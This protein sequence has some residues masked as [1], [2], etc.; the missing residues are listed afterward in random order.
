[1]EITNRVRML[2]LAA[3]LGTAVYFS[4]VVAPSAFGVL[5]SFELSNASEVAGAIVSRTLS[6]VNKTGALLSFLLL[7]TTLSVRR[8]YGRTS[9]ILQNVLLAVVVIATAIGEWVIAPRMVSLRVLMRGQI[10]QIPLT[11]P[12]RITFMALH[13]YSVAALGVAMIAA[14]VALVLMALGRN[15]SANSSK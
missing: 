3:W 4:V 1:M 11:D 12:A 13:R 8:S 14:L 15:Q 5:R 10:D 9:F 7:L 6:T 2:L